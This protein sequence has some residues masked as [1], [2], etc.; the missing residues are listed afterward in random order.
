[1]V[2]FDSDADELAAVD[3]MFGAMRLAGELPDGASARTV[4]GD[5]LAL[6]FADGTFDKI[7]AAEVLEHIPDDMGAMAELARVLR[8]GGRL[9]ASVPAYEWAWSDFD[10]E[11]GHH[12]RYTR[13]RATAVVRAAGLEVERVTH[14]FAAVF[15]F[16]AAERLARRLRRRS[17]AQG[18]RAAAD[19]VSLPEVSPLVERVLMLL[20][21]LDRAVLRTRDLPFGSSVLVAASKA[22]A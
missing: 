19:I 16:F 5:A 15:P 14:A 21:S 17:R 6:P 10:E 18:P 7:I 4:H 2:A 13:S 8:P 12:R 1:V 11:N 22:R 9:L 3:R 20:T